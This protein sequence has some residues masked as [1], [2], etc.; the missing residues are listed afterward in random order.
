MS[1]HPIN[2]RPT[3][4]IRAWLDDQRQRRG[5]AINALVILALEQAMIADVAPQAQSAET[6]RLEG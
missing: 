4:A 6:E 1:R 2:I 3:P 5:L